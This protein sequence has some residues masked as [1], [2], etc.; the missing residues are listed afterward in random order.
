MVIFTGRETL[1]CSS[2]FILNVWLGSCTSYQ[3]WKYSGKQ[4]RTLSAKP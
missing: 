3:F 2:R 1:T 4:H